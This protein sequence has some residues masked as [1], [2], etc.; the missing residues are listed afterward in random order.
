[1]SDKKWDGESWWEDRSLGE[2]VGIGIGLAVLAVGLF[3]LYG[4]L[5][6]TLWNWLMPDLFGFKAMNYWQALGLPLLIMLLF[7]GVG[8]GG[9]EKQKDRKRKRAL[10]RAIQAENEGESS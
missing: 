6:M 1:M 10:R 9:G 3:F 7:M 4:W 5:V 8:S 2:K